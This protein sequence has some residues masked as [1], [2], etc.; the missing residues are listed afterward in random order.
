[1]YPIYLTWHFFRFTGNLSSKKLSVWNES[2]M[3][4]ANLVRGINA[5][6]VNTATGWY[7]LYKINKIV[8]LNLFKSRTFLDPR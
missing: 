8:V 2:V 3:N 5:S 7:Y 6:D 1:M 4:G